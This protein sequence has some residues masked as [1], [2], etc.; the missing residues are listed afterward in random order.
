MVTEMEFSPL[1]VS[2]DPKGPIQD[3][4]DAEIVK[5]VLANPHFTMKEV[6]D[7]IN[8]KG[9]LKKALTYRNLRGRFKRLVDSK[10]FSKP[11]TLVDV[12]RIGADDMFEVAVVTRPYEFGEG[13]TQ[14]SLA[15]EISESIRTDP[16]LSK[17]IVLH[18]I[19]ILYGGDYDLRI[20]LNTSDKK[21]LFRFVSNTLRGNS[22]IES[23]QTIQIGFVVDTLNGV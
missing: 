1:D 21:G 8:A 9:I 19:T 7:A 17:H 23:T 11:R 4:I 22:R 13:E 2:P 12:S 10:V 5:C 20:T 15:E 16:V 6:C 18:S 14:E 3:V